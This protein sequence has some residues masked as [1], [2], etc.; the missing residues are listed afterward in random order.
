MNSKN[1]TFDEP[2]IFISH[3]S[4]DNTFTLFLAESLRSAKINVWVDLDSIKQRHRW[5]RSI[6]NA[7]T[8]CTAVIVVMSTDGRE[9]EWVERETLLALDLKKPIYVALLEEIQLPLHLINLQYTNFSIRKEDTVTKFIKILKK[10][11]LEIE[12]FSSSG[13]TSVA[14]E[15]ELFS[16]IEDSPNGTNN[17][18][19]ARSLYHWARSQVQYVEFSGDNILAFNA[20]LWFNGEKVT[21]M[22]VKAYAN[23][24]SV[25]IPFI[26]LKKHTPLEKFET[27]VSILKELN[28]LMPHDKQFADSKADLRPTIP[29]QILSDPN[30]QKIF[31]SAM[32]KIMVAFGVATVMIDKSDFQSF[33]IEEIDTPEA[34]TTLM[35]P[36]VE[37]DSSIKQ[38][39]TRDNPDNTTK[40]DALLELLQQEAE[41]AEEYHFSRDKA[42]VEIT[43]MFSTGQELIRLN[44]HIDQVIIGRVTT[45]PAKIR[46]DLDL[47]PY[48]ASKMGVSRVHLSIQYSS[49]DK[50][51]Y[52]HDL[53]S[54]NGTY[55]NGQ[56][57]RGG[58]IRVLSDGDQLRLG[59]LPF[60]V[61]IKWLV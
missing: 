31:I 60:A 3:S 53:G 9:S 27:R 48:G 40:L 5:L 19:L 51:L 45:S 17:T 54:T 56:Q 4:E 1:K 41:L 33:L 23:Q 34:E 38:S 50:V 52:M 20:R 32:G 26:Y 10:D 30:A 47:S 15:H 11:I 49:E 39:A 22:S 13:K 12:M 43:F 24:P 16:R 35:M 36:V 61:F 42:R 21:I 37:K 29:L 28:Q 57:V 59:G 2:Y 25:E 18:R 55:L 7:I 44:E 6:E 14:E 58:E 8:N 46:P